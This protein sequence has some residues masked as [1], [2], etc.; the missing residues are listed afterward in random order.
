MAIKSTAS[1]LTISEWIVAAV[2]AV[3]LIACGI[4]LLTG[5]T[6]GEAVPVIVAQMEEVTQTEAGFLLQAK[7]LNR[8]DEA[9]A[10]VR[11]NAVLETSGRPA[12]I[13]ESV[14]D[15]VPAHSAKRIGFY[16]VSDPREGRLEL[17]AHSFVQP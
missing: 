3:V 12:E 4:I 5:S 8:G 10:E 13:R 2:G 9:A 7:V 1:K 6:G 17:Q 14:L 11:I 15:Y 16:F